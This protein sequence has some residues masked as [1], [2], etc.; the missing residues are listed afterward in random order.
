M[1]SYFVINLIVAFSVTIVLIFHFAVPTLAHAS[2]AERESETH[3]SYSIPN[4]GFEHY[5]ERKR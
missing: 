4:S 2:T 1:T 5:F 3:V